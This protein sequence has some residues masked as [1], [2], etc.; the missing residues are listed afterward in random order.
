MTDLEGSPSDI[1]QSWKDRI[2]GKFSCFILGLEALVNW[3]VAEND[4]N[5]SEYVPWRSLTFL[6]A[7][8]PHLVLY[9]SEMYPTIGVAIPSQI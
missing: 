6:K 3:N 1:E 2:V 5:Q 4:Q 8:V 9:L 7:Y